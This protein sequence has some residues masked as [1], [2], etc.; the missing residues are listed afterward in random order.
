MIISVIF[1]Q[2]YIQNTRRG[3]VDRAHFYKVSEG[4]QEFVFGTIDLI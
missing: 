3:K 4:I 1:V 2:S